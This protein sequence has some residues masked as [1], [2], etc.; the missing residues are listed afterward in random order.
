[1]VF[2]PAELNQLG[3]SV[4]CL[5]QVVLP[6]GSCINVQDFVVQKRLTETL[7]RKGQVLAGT[8]YYC[9]CLSHLF[10]RETLKQTIFLKHSMCVSPK[11]TDRYERDQRSDHSYIDSARRVS[12]IS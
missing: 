1:M 6:S 5:N 12:A 7:T 8:K 10:L 2:Y 3:A 9:L 11:K 4:Q